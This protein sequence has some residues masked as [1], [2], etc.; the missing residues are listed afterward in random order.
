MLGVDNGV[1]PGVFS[2][3]LSDGYAIS[4]ALLSGFIQ[5]R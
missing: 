3:A 4:G 5:L 2:L 1:L